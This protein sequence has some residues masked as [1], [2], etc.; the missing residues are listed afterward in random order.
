MLWNAKN[1]SVPIKNTQMSYV[2][3]GHGFRTLVILPGLSDGLATVKGKALLLAKPYS[4]FFDQYTVYMF[5]RRDDLPSGHTIRDMASDQAD[6]LQTLGLTNASIM[7]VSQGGMIA[8]WLAI[9]RPELVDRLVLAVT[10]PR[11]NNIIRG[12][13]I[14]WINLAEQG[15]HKELMIDTAEKSYSPAYLQKYRK[16]YPIFGLVGKPKSYDRFLAN[17]RAI[18]EFD[19]YEKLSEIKMPT[20]II[21]GEKDEIVGVEASHELHEQIVGSDL[22]IYP[23]LGHAAYE[24][25]T[26][27]NQRVFGFLG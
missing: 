25:A 13:V 23:G 26:D 22:F 4:H 6:A 1:G 12:S 7:G 14:K 11:V 2:S 18:L 19:A 8:Q 15:N 24:E 27:F 10:A 16:M 21:G 5:S 9:D 20:L 17:A 3:F